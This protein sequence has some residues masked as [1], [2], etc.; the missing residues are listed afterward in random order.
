MRLDFSKN[1]GQKTAKS[2][3]PTLGLPQ[4]EPC[5]GRRNLLKKIAHA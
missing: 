2:D 1:E 3:P 5:P 4:Y